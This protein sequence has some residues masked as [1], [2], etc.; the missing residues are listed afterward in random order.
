MDSF[1][2]FPVQEGIG[3]Y[4][5]QLKIISDSSCSIVGIS[6]KEVK[7]WCLVSNAQ[8]FYGVNL[9]LFCVQR[10]VKMRIPANKKALSF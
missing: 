10:W 3:L 8:G 4:C 7:I 1:G 2:Y 6:S 5:F 9:G